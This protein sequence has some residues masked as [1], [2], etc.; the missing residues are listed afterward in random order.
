LEETQGMHS[1]NASQLGLSGDMEAII[2]KSVG[3]LRLKGAG[4]RYVHG[5][6]AL[7]EVVIPVVKINKKRQSDTSVVGVEIL[8][9]SSSTIT[10]GQLAVT[11][12][13]RDAVTDK[14]RP[15][16]LRAGIY[17]DEGELISNTH[18]LPFDS[19]SENP[20]DRE[21]VVRFILT[22]RAEKA[23]GKEVALKLEERLSGTAHYT[24]YASRRYI[25]RRSF[26][27]DFD[28]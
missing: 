10:S 25:M 13:Q 2:P 24:E 5:G 27:S 14:M 3:R 11:L 22:G 16:T 9:G 28:L 8:S 4:S 19:T 20:R 18:E 17:T 1:F 7:Q 12:Y 23:N 6:A 21:H 15:R 26:T